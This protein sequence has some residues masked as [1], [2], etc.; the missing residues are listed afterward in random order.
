MAS[1]GAYYN[2]KEGANNSDTSR[3]INLF[4]T[5]GIVILFKGD[6]IQQREIVVLEPMPFQAL[7]CEGGA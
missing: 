2:S 1:N 4:S 6:F 3:E 5:L 7:S